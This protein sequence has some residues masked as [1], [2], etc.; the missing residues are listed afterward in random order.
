MQRIL[1]AIA[2][3]LVPGRF[4]AGQNP[5]QIVEVRTLLATDAAH[6]GSAVKAAV[7]A[8][9]AP[10][11]HINS[12][13]P[14]LDYLIPTD[15]KLNGNGR[16]NLEELS[17]PKGSLKKLAFSDAPL[18]VYEG[19]LVVGALLKV[20][21]GVP[22]GAY[23]LE[24]KFSF[25]ACNDHACLPPASV[26]VTLTVRVVSP[27]VPLKRQNVDVFAQLKFE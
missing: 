27:T 22:P 14:S 16:V 19:Q 13:Q 18:S 17:F 2:C 7:V 6:P 9:I 10:G 8:Q 25:Q 15:L 12:H 26:P 5:P 11:Y 23:K 4:F 3:L 1:L 20:A 24:G 21:K